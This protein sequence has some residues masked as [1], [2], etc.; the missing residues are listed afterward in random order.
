MDLSLQCGMCASW[1]GGRGDKVA[2]G[3]E[4]VE[5]GLGQASAL[6]RT[7]SEWENQKCC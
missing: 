3:Q 7:Q 6:K 2:E 1:A 4:D 5:A